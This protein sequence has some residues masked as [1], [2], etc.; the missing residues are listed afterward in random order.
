MSS[1][2]PFSGNYWA[3]ILGASSGFGAATAI[4]LAG[5]GMSIF[6]VHFDRAATM[7]NVERIV[8]QIKVTGSKVLFFNINASDT[9]KRAETLEAIQKELS[10]TPDATIRVLLHSLAFG[11]LKS[12]IGKKPDDIIS[13][14]QMDMT[15]DVMAHSL[16]YWTQD[17]IM[18]GLM[19][20]GGRIFA[21]TSSGGQTVLPFYGAVSAAKAAL[22]SHIR[23]LAMELGPHGVTAN[24]ILAGV[25]DTPALRK[26]PGAQKM[27]EIAKA[28]NPQTRSTTPEDVAKAIA[29]LCQDE[30]YFISG[31]VIGVDGGETVVNYVGQKSAAEFE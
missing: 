4:E 22:E 10:S 5:R 23:Q 11:T 28:K 6:G 24:S 12:Y 17:V 16:V 25:T 30:A 8:N 13:K 9:A 2:R 21:M 31:N 26:I 19:K 18:R 14:A 7:P 20:R 1:T 3:L 27:L 15:L 29:L